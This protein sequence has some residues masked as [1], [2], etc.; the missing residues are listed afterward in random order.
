[1]NTCRFRFRSRIQP[2]AL[3]SAGALLGAVLLLQTSARAQDWANLS[4]YRAD[5]QTLEAAPA[6]GRRVVFMGDSITDF[7]IK[8]SREFFEQPGYIDRGI[9]GQTTPQMLL[10]FRQDVVDLRPAVVLILAGTND[11]AGNTGPSSL[12]MIED[13]LISMTQ[14]AR[15]NRIRVILCSVLPAYDYPWRKGTFPAEKIRRLNG[16]M[17]QYAAA[18]RVAYLDYYDALVDSRGGMK[19]AYSIDGVHPNEAGYRVMEPLAQAAIHRAL[20]RRA[21]RG[22]R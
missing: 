20:K 21:P 1:M 2:A 16:W 14:L 4:R 15:A 17:Q 22:L 19:E 7:W 9:S 18:H 5:D 3:R 8:R 10:R 13:N 6:R 12:K 11:I